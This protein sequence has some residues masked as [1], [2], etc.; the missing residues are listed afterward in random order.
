MVL[1]DVTAFKVQSV[2]LVLLD[3]RDPLERTV[4]RE[5]SV[6]R[7][8]REAKETRANLVHQVQAVFRE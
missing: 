1:L 3:P 2:F 8:R 4:T 6:D 7:D 5:K